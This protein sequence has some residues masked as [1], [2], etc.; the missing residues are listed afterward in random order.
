MG[1]KRVIRKQPFR[2]EEMAV[3]AEMQYRRM[4]FLVQREGRRL[5]VWDE[6]DATMG[7]KD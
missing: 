6:T 3:E 7:T 1:L 5:S 4:G 2:N